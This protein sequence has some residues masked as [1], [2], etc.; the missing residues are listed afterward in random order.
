MTPKRLDFTLT[1]GGRYHS[2]VEFLLFLLSTL[3][4]AYHHLSY[5]FFVIF[6]FLFLFPLKNIPIPKKIIR[7]SET[8]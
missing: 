5:A 3:L 1:F 2:K 7:I 4:G 8:V 6:T